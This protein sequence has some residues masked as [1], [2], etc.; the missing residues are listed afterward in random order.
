VQPSFHRQRVEGYAQAMVAH[1]SRTA[2]R[3]RDGGEIDVAAEMTQLTL[4]IVGDTLFGT[5]VGQRRQSCRRRSAM[6][7]RSFRSPCRRSRRCWSGC[8]CRWSAATTAPRRDA[9]PRHLPHHRRAAQ[10]PSDRGDPALDAAA[11][12]RR[13]SSGAR[14]TDTQVRDEAMTLFL[15]G[16]RRPPTRS[17]WA[18]HL[19]AQHPDVERRLHDE[20]RQRDR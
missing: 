13:G 7:S 14:M 15:A 11:G 1:A 3:W 19:L 18:W 5:D 6:S 4:T 10:N 9:R 8:R 2:E 16:T 17:T 20:T 12:A